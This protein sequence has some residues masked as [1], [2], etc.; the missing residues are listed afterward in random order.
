MLGATNELPCFLYSKL[1][2]FTAIKAKVMSFFPIVLW[3]R[4]QVTFLDSLSLST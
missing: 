3:C 2:F 4:L 1:V